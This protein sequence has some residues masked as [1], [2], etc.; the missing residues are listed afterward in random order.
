MPLTS[1]TLA[2]FLWEPV[3]GDHAYVQCSSRGSSITSD[4]VESSGNSNRNNS[5][6]RGESGP[7]SWNRELSSCVEGVEENQL[8]SRNASRNV[9]SNN[10]RGRGEAGKSIT[11]RLLE[12]LEGEELRV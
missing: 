5:I 11:Q 12:E 3:K 4:S 7:L 6:D 2:A 10:E 9:S 1:P 8:D